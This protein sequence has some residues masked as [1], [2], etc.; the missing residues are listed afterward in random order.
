[1]NKQDLNKPPHFLESS[2]IRLLS[3]LIFNYFND[4][5][6]KNF[7]YSNNNKVYDCINCKTKI[8]DQDKIKSNM[9]LIK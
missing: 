4:N 8:S 2:L 7:I 1:M 5:E 6:E 3:H 9:T